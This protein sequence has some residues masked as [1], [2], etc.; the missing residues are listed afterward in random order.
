MDEDMTMSAE[1]WEVLKR[2]TDA[3]NARQRKAWENG[4]FE[5]EP[6]GLS[7]AGMLLFV[8]YDYEAYEKLFWG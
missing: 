1:A 8:L 7:M 2:I 4:D 5:D 3:H 6:H